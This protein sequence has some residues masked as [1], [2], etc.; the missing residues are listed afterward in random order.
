VG[1]HDIFDAW[2]LALNSLALKLEPGLV[3]A[4]QVSKQIE[5]NA[6][7]YISE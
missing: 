2:Q 6:N 4:S 1:K 5:K 3:L 7:T